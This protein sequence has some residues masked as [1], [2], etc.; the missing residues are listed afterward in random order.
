M[1]IKYG[2]ED[3][4]TKLICPRHGMAPRCTPRYATIIHKGVTYTTG[5]LQAS[6]PSGPCDLCWE[7]TRTR[8]EAICDEPLYPGGPWA[9]VCIS[10]NALTR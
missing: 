6:Q 5:A 4:N 1:T 10:H 3:C 9:N 2:C 7:Q 8:V